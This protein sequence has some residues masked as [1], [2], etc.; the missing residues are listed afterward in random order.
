MT[1]LRIGGHLTSVGKGRL[2]EGSIL[3]QGMRRGR[4][5]QSGDQRDVNQID[6]RGV[7]GLED[8]SMRIE[9]LAGVRMHRFEREDIVRS[10]LVLRELTDRDEAT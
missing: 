10:R 5:L 8:P 4:R 7:N 9:G 3:R 1:L 6:I 2:P